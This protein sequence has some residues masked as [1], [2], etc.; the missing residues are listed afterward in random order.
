MS[1]IPDRR[2][3]ARLTVPRHL[4]GTALEHHDVLLLDCGPLGARITHRTPLHEGVGCA[5][6]FP[7]ALGPLRL[8]GRV[9]WTRIQ[10]T[11]QTLAGDR[12]THYESG[13]EFTD[14]APDEQTALAATLAAL[15]V[16]AAPARATVLCI[17]DD[18][19]VLYFYR[20]FL[21]G[22]GYRTLAVL[23][24]LQGLTLAHQDRPDV[25]LLD[26]MLRGLSGFDICRKLRADPALR[27]IPILLLTAWNHP[28][29]ATT[30][31]AAGATRTL[32][33][34]TDPETILTVLA[35]VLGQQ[36]NA[37]KGVA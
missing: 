17:D 34:P 13:I 25:I 23:D 37:P 31:H 14:L 1:E 36:P 35:Q 29:V 20:D 26:V 9:V 28:S 32:Q 22:H 8:T 18:P 30:G 10:S 19:L 33:K 16:A 24:G 6:E 7:P 4:R 12:R 21:A 27:D 2:R 3:V 11:E 5:V 15:P